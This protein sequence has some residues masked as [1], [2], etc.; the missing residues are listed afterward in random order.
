[1]R[2]DF[3]PQLDPIRITDLR[4]TQMTIGLREV[5]R[6]RLAWRKRAEVDGADFLGSHMIPAVIGPGEIYFLIDQH[7]LVRALHEEGVSHVLVS[8][9]GDL[10][11]L[12]KPM[13]WTFM[14][15]RNWLHPFDADGKRHGHDQIP[16]KIGDLAD[17]P[18][19]S[20]A[21]ELRRSGGYA[22]VETPYSEFLWADFLRHRVSRKLVEKRFERA[23][24]KALDLAHHRDADYLP[25]WCG[26]AD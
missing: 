10:R 21:G 20:L 23:V 3:Q 6:K 22:K 9:V 12:R 26:P 7:H 14:D 19:R 24:G 11:H 16:R 5:E 8:V 25:G 2:H 17:D 18:Y 15:N 4:P 1:V 13:F